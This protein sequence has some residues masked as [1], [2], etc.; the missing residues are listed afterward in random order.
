MA[1]QA[2][3]TAIRYYYNVCSSPD[4][5]LELVMEGIQVI[6]AAYFHCV[7]NHAV[8]GLLERQSSPSK[9]RDERLQLQGGD[10][11]SKGIQPSVSSPDMKTLTVCCYRAWLPDTASPSTAF[12]WAPPGAQR[13]PPRWIC[14]SL[15]RSWRN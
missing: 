6:F 2:G 4:N 9:K 8:V 5:Q 15:I 1:I 11:A 10:G 12:R 7:C 3:M 13:S 14:L